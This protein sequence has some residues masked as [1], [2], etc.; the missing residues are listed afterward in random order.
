MTTCTHEGGLEL[1]AISLEGNISV[2]R[3]ITCK[4]CGYVWKHDRFRDDKFNPT[5]NHEYPHAFRH[6]VDETRILYELGARKDTK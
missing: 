3:T 5:P 4:L 6:P 1:T 2:T